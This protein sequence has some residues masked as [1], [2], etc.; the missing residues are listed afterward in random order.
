V[1]EITAT[2]DAGPGE[3]EPTATL[4]RSPPAP[5]TRLDIGGN[6]SQASITLADPPGL[7]APIE[8]FFRAGPG[9]FESDTE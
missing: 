2:A 3:Y 1:G 9:P 8:A 6:R 5:E 7:D 4:T